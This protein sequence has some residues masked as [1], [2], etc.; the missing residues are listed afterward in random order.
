MMGAAPRP[1]PV[2]DAHTIATLAHRYTLGDVLN[3]NMDSSP[4]DCS[5]EDTALKQA[6]MHIMH[7]LRRKK[8]G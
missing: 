3:A 1:L 6:A 4:P 2:P 7:A 5:P 8:I